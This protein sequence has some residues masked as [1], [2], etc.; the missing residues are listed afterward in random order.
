MK[1]LMIE[2]RGMGLCEVECMSNDSPF[3]NL[4]PGVSLRS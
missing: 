3:P 4:H 2:P 1:E